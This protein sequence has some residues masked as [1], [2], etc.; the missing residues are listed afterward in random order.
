MTPASEVLHAGRYGSLATLNVSLIRAHLCTCPSACA[1]FYYSNLVWQ[2]D[3]NAKLSQLWLRMV[4]PWPDQ[5]D[6]FRRLCKGC[7]LQDYLASSS[8][9]YLLMH[10]LGLKPTIYAEKM[11]RNL[12]FGTRLETI[13]NWTVGSPEKFQNMRSSP[14]IESIIQSIV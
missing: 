9:T 3:P 12:I 13:K 2:R 7:G 4:W 10:C 14:N 11:H 6:R 1:R 8:I 5:P